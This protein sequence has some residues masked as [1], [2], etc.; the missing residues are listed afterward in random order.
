MEAKQQKRRELPPMSKSVRS[1]LV[2]MARLGID[3]KTAVAI[4]A[5]TEDSPAAVEM[6]TL[7]LR[8]MKTATKH[9]ALEAMTKALVKH[10]TPE[11][12]QTQ[13]KD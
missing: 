3:S 4:W 8:E 7:L 10:P 13:M 2:E 11:M 1:L 9:Q 12:I 6:T 5:L